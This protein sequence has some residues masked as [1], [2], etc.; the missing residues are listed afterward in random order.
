M[1]VKEAIM[2]L[3]FCLA[4]FGIMFICELQEQKERKSKMEKENKKEYPSHDPFRKH[5]LSKSWDEITGDSIKNLEKELAGVSSMVVQTGNLMCC[6][7]YYQTNT[8]ERNMRNIL[9][10]QDQFPTLKDCQEQLE[11][12]LGFEVEDVVLMNWKE[13]SKD[14]EL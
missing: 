5:D 4:V 9:I 6:C 2:I 1:T 3:G 14:Y 11:K 7:S 10:K 12:V 13:V 8:K